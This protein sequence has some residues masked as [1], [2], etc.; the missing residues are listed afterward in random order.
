MV[1]TLIPVD[2]GER[3]AG[4]C[5]VRE[6]DVRHTGWHVARRR[7][8]ELDERVLLRGGKRKLGVEVDDAHRGA[9]RAGDIGM[10][11][12]KRGGGVVVDGVGA[13]EQ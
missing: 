1:I 13:Q 10:V 7:D 12:E 4:A 8:W 6:R 9:R 3:G 11:L 2:E 5:A